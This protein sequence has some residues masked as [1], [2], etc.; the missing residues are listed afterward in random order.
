MRAFCVRQFLLATLGS[1]QSCQS[2]PH[3][4]G[5]QKA[6]IRTSVVRQVLKDLQQRKMSYSVGRSCL[7]GLDQHQKPS[8]QACSY[9]GRRLNHRH[10]LAVMLPCHYG[11]QCLHPHIQ[12]QCFAT[13]PMMFETVHKLLFSVLFPAYPKC[14]SDW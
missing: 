14:Y 1:C 3:Q 6:I 11:R 8:G 13:M 5:L 7:D 9:A 2:P 10:R 4:C 12:I